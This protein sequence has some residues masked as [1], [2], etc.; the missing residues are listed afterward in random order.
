LSTELSRREDEIAVTRKELGEVRTQDKRVRKLREFTQRKIE[1]VGRQIE[2]HEG[3]QEGLQSEMKLITADLESETAENARLKKRHD[4][5]FRE[6]EILDKDSVKEE[7]KIA[8]TA[9]LLKIHS[10]TKKNF[11]NEI[12]GYIAEARRQREIIEQLDKDVHRYDKEAEEANQ[13]YYAALEE[14]KYQE[15]QLGDLQVQ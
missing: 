5:L 9:G 7:E 12:N 13:M 15:V 4:E 8:Q 11:E 2:K 6:R 14:V 1:K 3:K 10:N